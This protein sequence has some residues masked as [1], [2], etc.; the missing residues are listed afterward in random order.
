MRRG[1]ARTPRRVIDVDTRHARQARHMLLVQP[2][3]RSTGDS[4]ENQRGFALM[5]AQRMHEALLE[6]SMIVEQQVAQGI[7]QGFPRRIRQRIAVAVVVGKTVVDDGLRH[8]LTAQ[9]AHRANLAFDADAEVRAGGNILPTVIAATAHDKP[10]KM[11][12]ARGKPLAPC[13]RCG[14]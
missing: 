7:G 10:P 14:L 13:K 9:A 12:K 6:F 1:H 11:K 4:L 3:A 5:L 8:R 2:D